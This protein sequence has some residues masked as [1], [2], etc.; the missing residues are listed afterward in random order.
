MRS[1]Y[2]THIAPYLDDIKRWMSDGA[3]MKEVAAKL[4]VSYS[5]FKKYVSL[6]E[7]GDEK[8]K[9][10]KAPFT[11]GK[12]YADDQVEAALFQRACGYTYTDR[13]YK[14]VRDPDTGEY[15]MILYREEEKH[16]PADP[17]SATFW[18]TNRRPDT[19]KYKREDK[20]EITSESGV[21]MMPAV[22]EEETNE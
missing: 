12:D 10:L 18:L 13:F 5:V 4:D 21:I 17:T 3:T 8:Y 15:E 2:E 1:K 7:K 20:V 9:D 16:M 11:Q 22:L 19:W 6:A 14:R